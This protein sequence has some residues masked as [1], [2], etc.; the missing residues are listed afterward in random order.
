M[1]GQGV[2][3]LAAF[4]A[5]VA[6]ASARRAGQP[7]TAVPYKV[8]GPWR[9]RTLS[10]YWVRGWVRADAVLRESATQTP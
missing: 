2:G 6:G 8:D 5:R 10:R 4:R 3:R 1:A 9:E 7:V